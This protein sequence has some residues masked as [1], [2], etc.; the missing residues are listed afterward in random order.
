MTQ[1]EFYAWCLFIVV[2]AGAWLAAG[3]P[4]F[5]CYCV[6]VLAGNIDVGWIEA[7]SSDDN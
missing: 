7:L 1:R 2:G 5:L 4:G 6:G 3:V